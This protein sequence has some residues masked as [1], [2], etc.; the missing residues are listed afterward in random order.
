MLSVHIEQQPEL[1]KLLQQHQEIILLQN[2]KPVAKI[3]P[4]NE[5]TK[6]QLGTATGLFQVSDDFNA[7]LDDFAEYS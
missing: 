4:I 5:P 1:F 6:R 2:N 3:T 7:P